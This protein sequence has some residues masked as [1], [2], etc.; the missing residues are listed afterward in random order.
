M[1]TAPE[2]RSSL[3]TMKGKPVT[4]LGTPVRTGDKAPDFRVVDAM[5]APTRMT[6]FRGKP[7]L[8]SVVP[9]LDTGVCALQT[10]RFNDEV[11]RLPPDL[12]VMTISMDLPFAQKR[13]CASEKVDRI[14]VL[15]DH[16]WREFGLNYGVLIKD[17]GLLARSVF[18]IDGNGTVAYEEIVPEISQHP[19]YDAALAACRRVAA[20][21]GQASGGQRRQ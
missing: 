17:M 20:G 10:K 16:V 6:Q 19:D 11:Q 14:R 2:E 21:S 1:T 4:L 5:F 13:F 9:S 18:V 12:V 3:V 7:C 8:I 15:S